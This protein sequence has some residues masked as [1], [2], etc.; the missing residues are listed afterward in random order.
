MDEV[1]CIIVSPGVTFNL[2]DCYDVMLGK[3]E[4]VIVTLRVI[5]NLVVDL[6]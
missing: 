6:F 3:V 1:K 2:S 4:M 5:D